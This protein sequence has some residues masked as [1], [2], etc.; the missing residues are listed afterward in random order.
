MFTELRDYLKEQFFRLETTI[1]SWKFDTE[2]MKKL[3]VESRE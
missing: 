1:K 3:Y 2:K